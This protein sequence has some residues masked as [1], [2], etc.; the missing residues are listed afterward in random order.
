MQLPVILA[1]LA[2][3]IHDGYF[4]TAKDT[5][6][7]ALFETGILACPDLPNLNYLHGILDD[8]EV[9][10]LQYVNIA[11][12]ELPA[13]L[14]A[15]ASTCNL[16]LVGFQAL[17]VSYYD[18]PL[19]FSAF[20]ALQNSEALQTLTELKI[21][22]F[23]KASDWLVR[24]AR[25]IR[26]FSDPHVVLLH[27]AFT[28]DFTIFSN[29]QQAKSWLALHPAYTPKRISVVSLVD[30]LCFADDVVD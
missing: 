25:P 24:F 29:S 12:D 11:D 30:S 6:P 21:P 5:L 17:L 9:L 27:D 19:T 2:T 1:N 3:F 28:S 7:D 8:L 23:S 18:D 16:Y 4:A 15:F 26:Y 10:A 14:A 22:A 20:T 13:D